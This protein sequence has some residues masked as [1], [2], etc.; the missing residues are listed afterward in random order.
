MPTGS[1]I[2][3]YFDGTW[4]DGDIAVMKAADHGMWLGSNVFDGARFANGLTPDLDRH[5][6]RV[7]ASAE[8]LMVTPTIS[9]DEMVEIVREGLKMYAPRR[10][11]LYPP[12]VL[13][14]RRRHVRDRAQGG[15][16]NRLCHLS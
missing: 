12:D 7:N 4:H 10:R 15:G 9:P 3:T 8:A 11:G 14:D 5:C 2:K 13:G 16:R 6:A 1:N